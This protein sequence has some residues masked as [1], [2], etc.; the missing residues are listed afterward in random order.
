MFESLSLTTEKIWK[1]D[2]S[3]AAFLLACGHLKN[4]IFYAECENAE[5][6]D[7]IYQKRNSVCINGKEYISRKK[8]NAA[9]Q[10]VRNLLYLGC[11]NGFIKSFKIK[12]DAGYYEDQELIVA[13]FE[14]YVNSV[15]INLEGRRFFDEVNKLKS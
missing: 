1:D 3:E 4:Y 2:N 7:Y 11:V 5:P 9:K 14:N 10:C 15:G 8:N 12:T 13:A 6:G